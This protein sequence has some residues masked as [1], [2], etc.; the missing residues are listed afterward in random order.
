VHL[1]AF[2]HGADVR[3]FRPSVALANGE[4]TDGSRKAISVEPSMT[5]APSGAVSIMRSV[6]AF[7]HITPP[8]S[9]ARPANA[10]T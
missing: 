7:C 3:P 8:V 4:R 10:R 9:T 1:G 6:A 5:T 2:A